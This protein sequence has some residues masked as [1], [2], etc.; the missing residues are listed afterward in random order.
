MDVS[1]SVF[2]ESRLRIECPGEIELSLQSTLTKQPVRPATGPYDVESVI[3]VASCGRSNK[4]CRTWVAQ[5][6]QSLEG[7]NREWSNFFQP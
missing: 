1:V 3:L 6:E 7:K 4:Q 2:G 5:L